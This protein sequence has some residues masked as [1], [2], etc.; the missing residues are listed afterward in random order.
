MAGQSSGR[1]NQR[2]VV[3]RDADAEMFEDVETDGNVGQGWHVSK[4][5]RLLREERGE[6]QVERRV[7]GS[8]DVR[9]SLEGSSSDDRQR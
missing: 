5:K 7:L 4:R 9:R 8:V 2:T 1:E 6:H 3:M